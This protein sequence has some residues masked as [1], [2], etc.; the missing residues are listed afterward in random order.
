MAG[1]AEAASV[2]AVIQIS[3]QVL[4]LCWKYYSGVKG[5]K[6]D[7]E[8]LCDEVAALN[9]VLKKVQGLVEG[10]DAARLPALNALVGQIKQCS[11]ELERLRHRLDPG[12]TRKAMRRLRFQDLKWP[13][14]S[15]DVDK[16]I[17]MLG[18]HKE[19]FNLAL[20]VD[21]TALALDIDGNLTQLMQD[22]KAG[23]EDLYL[24]KLPYAD[25]A[26]FNSRQQEREPQ[27]L[28]S[29]RAEL[30]HQVMTWSD[31]PRGEC[32]FWLNGMAGTG[33]STIARTVARKLADQ[34][35]LG[36][37]FFFTRGGGDLAK[38]TRFFGSLTHQLANMLPSLKVYICKNIANDPYISQKYLSIQWDQLLLQ[39]LKMLEDSIPQSPKTLIF[40]IDALDECESE[41]DIK[42]ILKLFTEA[43][44]LKDIRLRVSV[45]SRPETPILLGFGALPEDVHQ[46]FVLHNISQPIVENNISIFVK[47]ELANIREQHKL[48]NI[49]KEYTLPAGWPGEQTVKILTRRADGLFIYAATVCRFIGDPNWSPEDRLRLVLKSRV[50]P[51]ENTTGQSPT[52]ELDEMYTNVLTHSVI[53]N[54]P[55]R[56]KVELTERF[57]QV[58]GSIVV[59]FDSLSATAL[60]KLLDMPEW[61]IDKTLGRLHS[62]LD[63][64]ERQVS[65]I[66]LLHPSFRDFLLDKQ[67]CSDPQFWVDEKEAH[68]DLAEHCLRLLSVSLR[69][70]IGD[71]SMPG[72][73]TSELNGTVER[74]LPVPVQYACRY[75]VGHLQQ[76]KVGLCDDNGQV[77][78]FLQ[79]H[80]LHW[81]EALSLMGKMS[82]GVLMLTALQSMLQDKHTRL[83]AMVYDAKRFI[84]NNRSIVEKAPLQVYNSAL[85]FSPERSVIR[86][87]FSRELPIWIESFPA[88]DRD[89]NPS[90]QALEGHSACVS[91]VAFSSDSRLL[92]SG[93]QD[94]S[95]KLWDPTTGELHGTLE[96]HSDSVSKVTFSPDSHLLASGSD[97]GT[98]GLWDLTTKELCGIF[99]GHLGRVLTVAFSPDGRLLA[100]ASVDGTVRLWDPTTGALHSTPGDHPHHGLTVTFSP[101][102]HLLA[103]G[104]N[105]GIVELWNL[106]TGQLHGTLEG[107]SDRVSKTVFSPDGRLLASGSYDHTV[108]LWD[109]TTRT[110]HGTLEG[111]S[112]SVWTVVFSP[113]NRLLAS[114]SADSTVRLWDPTTRELHATLGGHSG[115]V[116]TMAFSPDSRLLASGS[117]G[118]IR[119]WDPTTGALRGTLEGHWGFVFTVAFSPDGYLLASGSSDGTVRL[120]DP[121]TVALRGPPEDHSDRV[122]AVTFSPDGSFLASTSGDHTVKLWDSTTGTLNGTLQGHSGRVL[123]V[124]FSLDNRLLASASHDHTIRLWD[125]TTR[126]SHGTLE[127]RLGSVST[128]EF[129]PDNRI[130][131]SGSD[132][133]MVVLWDLTTR[134][135]HATLEGHSDSISTVVF[136]P[137]SRLLASGSVDS[138]IRLWNP[139]TGALC[140]TLESHSGYSP[141]VIFSPDS[142]LLACGSLD[143]SIVKLWDIE[144]KEQIQQLTTECGISG[145]S[146]SMDGSSLET[147]LDRIQLGPAPPHR[148]RTLSHPSYSLD[149][150]GQWVTWNNCNV[151]FLPRDRRPS[152]RSTSFAVKGNI[153]AIG[154]LLGRVT[155][156]RF[157]SDTGPLDN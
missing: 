135:L 90:L 9:I 145:L 101:D 61:K 142:R 106:T 82:E 39:P 75:W 148:V 71:L 78:V 29:T 134:A 131:A 140:G 60:V 66:R 143:H 62:I 47:H 22:V 26:A 38:T 16:S 109:P 128:M 133:C 124:A 117:L 132:N 93:S 59:L 81:I 41:D 80:F 37:S 146:F 107:H 127:G 31:N 34:N 149:K 125:P 51:N 99:E 129:S 24:A 105:D 156:L 141:T 43:K 137:D 96:G 116:L 21:Q 97:N 33:K 8:R 48:A 100:T 119:I 144:T 56:H 42:Q 3:Q 10:P 147:G 63:V 102:S 73:L 126:V 53:G 113:D 157:H 154:H 6:K 153:L 55:D 138:T 112:D 54:C 14:T 25:G 40:V 2:I 155:I 114:G 150:T 98:I 18:R 118:G 49:R 111:H 23:S 76:S 86:R 7:V 77:H 104:S 19:T 84:L 130:L 74:Y 120:W 36:A 95:I 52:L 87:E 139:T 151:L 20:T 45:T 27:C 83:F 28:P 12:T 44:N 13:F 121:T 30:L 110:L 32:I 1:L 4:A 35:R 89:W 57:R 79:T 5:A 70:D 122:S 50:T 103:S 68:K 65:S 88:V 46:D 72:A 17:A 69:R 85:V 123:A 152:D 11:P 94:R 58:V 136:S 92:A 64:S 15:E 115:V 67:R 91:E 108:R